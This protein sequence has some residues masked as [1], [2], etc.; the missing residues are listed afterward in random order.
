M[1]EGLDRALIAAYG[2]ILG[3]LKTDEDRMEKLEEFDEAV[4]VDIPDWE[5]R[6]K[7]YVSDKDNAADCIRAIE[8][9]HAKYHKVDENGN[10][11]YERIRFGNGLHQIVIT[12]DANAEG[13]DK[14]TI[15]EV[16]DIESM[17]LD[18]LQEYYE[19][20]EASV[21]TQ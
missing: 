5:E 18:A 3:L 7:E 12:Y 14:F 15:R 11:V 21:L 10:P 4:V 20:V 19:N 16:P 2:E 8:A 9:F 6:M 17:D 1:E 13:K